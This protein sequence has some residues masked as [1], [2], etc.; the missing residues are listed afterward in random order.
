[1]IEHVETPSNPALNTDACQRAGM[2]RLALRWTSIRVGNRAM[3]S[4]A[5]LLV[6][7]ASVTPAFSADGGVRPAALIG[8]KAGTLGC[9]AYEL[10]INA[11][12]DVE[13]VAHG[14]L[15]STSTWH[16]AIETAQFDRL[17][18]FMKAAGFFELPS[19]LEMKRPTAE[20]P[21]AE[22]Y[23]DISGS[24]KTV[25]FQFEGRTPAE[26]RRIMQ[27]I[28]EAVSAGT[29]LCSCQTRPQECSPFE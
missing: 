12:G 5:L 21:W 9:P 7:F 17:L 11:Q 3:L 18:H 13:Y 14:L 26:P 6:A 8:L 22:I 1:V 10:T 19:R 23:V 20:T 27:R 25:R 2:R 16:R 29:W 24:R 28:L 15:A 4:V